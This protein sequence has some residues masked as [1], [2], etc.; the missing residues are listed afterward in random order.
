MPPVIGEAQCFM[1]N[2]AILFYDKKGSVI[3]AIEVSFACENVLTL[4]AGLNTGSWC[5]AKF[6]SL[7]EFFERSGIRFYGMD[8]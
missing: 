2:N 6:D 3:A 4:P 1:P 7:R 5:R 8:D